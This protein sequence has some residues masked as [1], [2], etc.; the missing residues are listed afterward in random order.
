M[1]E[2]SFV[3][4]TELLSQTQKGIGASGGADINLN[5]FV[6]LLTGIV[7]LSANVSGK[8]NVSTSYNTDTMAKTIIQNTQ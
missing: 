8:I 2:D 1:Q 6:Y 4:T 7:G 5:P 3:E